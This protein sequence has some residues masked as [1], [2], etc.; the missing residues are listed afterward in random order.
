M[1]SFLVTVGMLGISV[2]GPTFAPPAP[3]V[4]DVAISPD[5][6]PSQLTSI[7]AAVASWN[8]ALPGE[9]LLRPS[10]G[11]CNHEDPGAEAGM[12][13][14]MSPV[15]TEDLMEAIGATGII[16]VTFRD[17]HGIGPW[18]I[19]ID[20]ESLEAGPP[21][22]MV[23]A[24]ELGHAMGL[25]HNPHWHTVMVAYMQNCDAFGRC[26][27]IQALTPTPEDVAAWRHVRPIT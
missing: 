16:G 1:M 21:Q 24:H 9:L 8:F 13:I 19:L 25:R 18:Q 6:T 23:E 22:Q 26:R 7:K 14:C 11:P 10:V 15:S 2:F 5:F 20:V 4:Y 12:L 17:D 3:R 27:T